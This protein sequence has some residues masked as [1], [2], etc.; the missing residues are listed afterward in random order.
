MMDSWMGKN[1]HWSN[2]S[3]YTF[4]L[5][6]NHTDP[7][8]IEK[9]A[10]ALIDKYVPKDN[11]YFTKFYLQPLSQ[12]YLQSQDLRDNMSTREGNIKTVKTVFFL[13]FLIIM[14]ACIN[15]M[16]LA[17][18]R[19]QKNAK[20]VGINKVLGAHRNQIKFRFYIETGIIAF[21]SITV[22]IILA[23][24]ALPT[25]NHIIGSGLAVPHLFTLENMGICLT[26]WLIITLVGGSYPAFI[27]AN[28]PSLSLMKNVITQGKIAQYLRKGLVIFQFTCSIILIIGV[29]IISL[30]MR[31]ISK[32]DLGYQATNIVT[33][34]IRS[35]PSMDKLK[36]IKESIQKLTGTVSIAT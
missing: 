12:V 16:N 14:I 21:L 10:T 19:S 20:E 34:P 17:T 24:V 1:V 31:H 29:I 13:S 18:A 2:A 8:Q 15:Y 32:K 36:N 6:S 28:I 25:F 22:G 33:I 3:Y 35:V 26:I 5:L 9:K 30:Q 11:Q 4:C 7:A 23:L 27:M